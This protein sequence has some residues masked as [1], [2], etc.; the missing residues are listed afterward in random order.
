V[1]FTTSQQNKNKP[2]NFT[3][4]SSP[5][6]GPCAISFWR[7]DFGDGSTSA[8]AVPTASHDYG[9]ANSGSTYNVTLTVTYPDGTAFLISPVTTR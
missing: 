6:T 8:G 1:S 7:W 2:V 3:S 4:T 9:S 5:T